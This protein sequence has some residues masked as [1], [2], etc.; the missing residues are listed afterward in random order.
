MWK[1]APIHRSNSFL[2]T[3]VSTL[4]T[5]LMKLHSRIQQQ[6]VFKLQ[7]LISTKRA[8]NCGHPGFINRPLLRTRRY[9]AFVTQRSRPASHP[10][11]CSTWLYLDRSEH[12]NWQVAASSVFTWWGVVADVAALRVVFLAEVCWCNR[13]I[14][15]FC[16]QRVHGWSGSWVCHGA[17]ST[18][19]DY[20]CSERGCRSVIS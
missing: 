4:I 9:I 20:R 5:P 10:H 11:S 16:D 1:S 14:T 2:V 18:L 7:P 13:A 19:T 12:F 6:H 8:V 17:A 3:L 15:L